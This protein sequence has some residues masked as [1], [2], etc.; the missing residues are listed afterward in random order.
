MIEYY[1]V[2]KMEESCSLPQENACGFLSKKKQITREHCLQVS[3]DHVR[4]FAHNI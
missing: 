2:I 1:E 3:R 4:A